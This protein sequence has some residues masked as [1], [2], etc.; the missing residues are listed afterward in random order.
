[1]SRFRALANST[2]EKAIA[3][4]MEA[5]RMLSALLHMKLTIVWQ[6]D[7][8]LTSIS[9]LLALTAVCIASCIPSG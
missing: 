2:L 9:S 1:M 3:S 6:V 8:C 7:I 5:R 4:A